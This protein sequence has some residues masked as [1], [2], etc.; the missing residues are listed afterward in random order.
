MRATRF[1]LPPAL[2][3]AL[4]LTACGG[5][6]SQAAS[7]AES[8]NAPDNAGTSATADTVAGSAEVDL[9]D[10]FTDRD[11]EIGYDDE[12]AGHITLLGD[13]AQADTDA[14][15]VNGSCVTITDEGTYVVAGTL[16]D[17]CLV[18]RADDTDKVQL[19]LNGASITCSDSAALYVAE[20]D[21][22]FVTTAA[23]T[24][25]TLANGGAYAENEEAN[26]DGAVF[27]RSDLTLNGAGSLAVTAAAGH[28]IVSKDDLVVTSGSYTITAASHALSGKDSVRIAGGDFTLDAGKDGIHA[29]NADDAQLGYVYLAGGDFVIDAQGDGISA[30]SWLIAEGGSYAITAGGGA[31]AAEPRTDAGFGGR[32]GFDAAAQAVDTADTSNTASTKGIKTGTALTLNGGDYTLDTA[33]DALHT[34]G[35]M[36]VTGGS[37]TIATGDDGLHADGALAIS[38]GTLTVTES[39]EGI[40]GL[41]VEITGGEI[42]V[43]AS[44]DGLNA[45]G[46]NDGSGAMGGRDAFAAEE[47]AYIAIAGGTIRVNAWGDGL[48]SNGDLTVS[49]G[50]VYVNGPSDAANGAL[51]YNG[52]ASITGGILAAASGAGGMEVNFGDGSAQGSILLSVGQQEAGTTLTLADA[53]GTVLLEWQP[54]KSYNTV[55]LSCPGLVDGG[56]YTVTAGDSAQ[57]V[58]LDGLIYGSGGMGGMGGMGG[59]GGMG[60]DGMTP[61]DGAMPGDG[62]FQKG[63]RPDGGDRTPPDDFDGAGLPDQAGAAQA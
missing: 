9:D 26:I 46:G 15:T 17:G 20:A 11:R 63:Q 29:E 43:T 53:D 47:G 21:K 34:N 54:A 7:T 6:G 24:Q 14:V 49:G 33:N 19:V 25:N 4:L 23:G 30:A 37:F 32:G 61:P 58:T 57:T 42:D 59:R 8:A 31:A 35:D 62:A 48:D 56:T 44:D 12:T 36:C 18:V 3:A 16:N 1:F 41:S 13:T 52:S 50:Q 39:Y 27:S 60:A 28:G 51:D 55:V 38:G 10:M 22:V 5:A 45:A 2:A 40:E